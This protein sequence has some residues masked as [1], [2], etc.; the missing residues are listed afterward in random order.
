[1]NIN[2][3]QSI[4]VKN[5]WY[6]LLSAIAFLYFISYYF[7][8]KKTVNLVS[9]YKHIQSQLVK[10]PIEKD[11][12]NKKNDVEYLN[13]LPLIEYI[14]KYCDDNEIEIK[15]IVQSSYKNEDGFNIE[16][17]KIVLTGYYSNIL[18]L[19][20]SIEVKQ[21]AILNSTKWELS[22][23]ISNNKYQLNCS[24][25]IKYLKNE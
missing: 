14:S 24:I 3:F 10:S 1:M 4:S 12:A 18:K 21:M 13:N 20:Y 6:L 23:G 9:S 19:L 22:K 25:Y 8:I 2:N 11:T 16:T 17:N 15:E 7:N 5:K